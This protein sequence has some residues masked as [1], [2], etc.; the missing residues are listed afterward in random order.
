MSGCV[1]ISDSMACDQGEEGKERRWREGERESFGDG[2][3]FHNFQNCKEYDDVYV[4]WYA[5][6]YDISKYR[7]TRHPLVN[8]V[9]LRYFLKKKYRKVVRSTV[10]ND[11]FCNIYR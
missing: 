8:I 5:A 2:F 11:I 1:L 7:T 10:P 9:S 6:W 3:H 4:V